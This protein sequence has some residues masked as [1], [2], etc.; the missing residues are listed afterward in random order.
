[1]NV[2]ARLFSDKNDPPSAGDPFAAVVTGLKTPVPR[3]HPLLAPDP[4][5]ERGRDYV[6]MRALRLLTHP[7]PYPCHPP[8]PPLRLESCLCG[9]GLSVRAGHS[10]SPSR[11]AHQPHCAVCSSK[12]MATV[13][14]MPRACCGSTLSGGG[15]LLVAGHDWPPRLSLRRSPLR[16]VSQ[17]QGGPR[18][19]VP[20]H[21]SLDSEHLPSRVFSFRSSHFNGS[22]THFRA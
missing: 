21:S 17:L 19:S 6:I 5:F 3:R 8:L 16:F 4:R 11:G 15:P 7:S 9:V 13:R 22:R 20:Y 1:M 10:E 14:C 18:E 2:C 12:R